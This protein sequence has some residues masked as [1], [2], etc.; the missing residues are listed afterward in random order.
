MESGAVEPAKGPAKVVMA[1]PG[2]GTGAG[3]GAARA[4]AGS[5]SAS[6]KHDARAERW[7]TKG[8]KGERFPVAMVSS[9]EDNQMAPQHDTPMTRSQRSWRTA[10]AFSAALGARVPIRVPMALYTKRQP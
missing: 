6:A 8:L 4:A 10:V 2:D 9:P 3:G 1:K 7:D 5:R